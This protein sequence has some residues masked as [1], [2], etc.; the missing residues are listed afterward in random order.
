LARWRE[1]AGIQWCFDEAAEADTAQAIQ[2]ALD[3]VRNGTA[4]NVKQ[5]RRK[6]LFPIPGPSGA[7]QLLLKRNHYHG[8][9][10]LLRRVR[11]S[12]SLHELRLARKVKQR[13]ID[14]PLPLAAGEDRS[15][16]A[17]EACYLLVPF[18]E[19][20]IDLRR[21]REAGSSPPGLSHALADRL[22]AFSRLIHDAGIFQDD[23]APNNFLLQQEPTLR[24]MMIDFERARL[25]R[26]NS[27][28]ARGAMLCKLDREL[29]GVSLASRARFLRSYTRGD[30]TDARAWWAEIELAGAK[31]ALR[32]YRRLSRGAGIGRR[33]VETHLSGYRALVATDPESRAL[34]DAA[35]SCLDDGSGGEAYRVRRLLA[36]SD[37]DGR[38]AFAKATLLWRRR[39]GPRPLGLLELPDSSALITARGPQSGPLAA[40]PDRS[41]TR[42][43]L[44]LL[45]DRLLALG[46]LV[47]ELTPDDFCAAED[48]ILLLAPEQLV[49]P[50][51]PAADRYARS[52]ALARIL[53][54]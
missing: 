40:N 15:G 22:G 27:R 28:A 9:Q 5:G 34:V 39:L 3:A 48:R 13:G 11:G 45:L 31:L 35:A 23:F 46:D 12:K 43:R 17:V 42:A 21:L 36:A 19:H 41:A 52:R 51:R 32:D 38:A 25:R 49:L 44:A 47:G 6:E 54:G 2:T 37:P 14:T 1:I 50:G 18:V 29:S 33:F 10:R 8:A 4:R 20:S 53:V 26:S 24:L 30:R 16:F 7:P